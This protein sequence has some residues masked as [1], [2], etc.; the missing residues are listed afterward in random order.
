[1]WLFFIAGIKY[2][3][4]SSMFNRLS[5]QSSVLPHCFAIWGIL[6]SSVPINRDSAIASSMGSRSCR[7]KFSLAFMLSASSSVSVF[8]KHSILILL[9]SRQA[10]KRR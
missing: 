4:Y 9:A 8:T 2:V 10:L 3:G 1:M 5:T 6:F 7:Y